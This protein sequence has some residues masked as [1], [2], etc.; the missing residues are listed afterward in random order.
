[1]LEIRTIYYDALSS[2]LYVDHLCLSMQHKINNLGRD[3]H[4]LLQVS[5]QEKV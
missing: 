5:P 3:I 2:A 1:M 4:T